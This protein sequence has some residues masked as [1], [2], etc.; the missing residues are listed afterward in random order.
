MDD[1][2]VN[3]HHFIKLHNDHCF[4]HRKC[5]ITG[6]IIWVALYVDDLLI[7]ANS[8]TELKQFKI[9]LAKSFKM[10]DLGAAEY[11][12]GIQITRDRSQR[13]L[14]INQS[15][16]IKDITS[17]FGLSDAREVDTPM[18]HKLRLSKDDCPKEMIEMQEMQK[19]PYREALGAAT[20]AMVGTRP[21]ISFV[22]TK[23]GQFANNPGPLHW[24]ALKRLLRYLKSTAHYSITYHNRNASSADQ[25]ILSGMADSDFASDQ[26]DCK[27][28]SGYAFVLAHGAL[29]WSA[30]R[31]TTVA[32]ST[33][34]SEYYGYNYAAREAVWL[35]EMMSQFYANSPQAATI[36]S[37]DNEGA[38]ALSKDPKFHQRTKHIGVQWHYVRERVKDHDIELKYV[39]TSKL[40]ADVLTKAL[41]KDQHNRCITQFGITSIRRK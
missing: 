16:Y 35:R 23:L 2:L 24:N 12:L 30:K 25:A 5:S 6:N 27:S 21:D 8:L 20:Y 28:V 15:R 19:V 11:V 31:Q 33:T 14:S 10:K 13:S 7:A 38:I 29:S 32:Q 17:R 37:A 3:K 39:H 22:I 40:G 41:T 4:Y 26:D 18:E 34:E 36:I 1:E 9:D